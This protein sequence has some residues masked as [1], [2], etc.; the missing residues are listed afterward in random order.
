MVDRVC[1]VF[2]WIHFVAKIVFLLFHYICPICHS[3]VVNSTL[4]LQCLGNV[5]CPA[6]TTAH[7]KPGKMQDSGYLWGLIKYFLKIIMGVQQLM[8]QAQILLWT[9]ATGWFWAKYCKIF[10][11][12]KISRVYCNTVI[13]V[14][15]LQITQLEWSF[16]FHSNADLLC[17]NDENY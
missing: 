1:K 7:N 6:D 13:I 3:S 11:L 5:L 10:Y 8:S 2:R 9:D 4:S 17:N 12:G 15:S 16:I 14:W